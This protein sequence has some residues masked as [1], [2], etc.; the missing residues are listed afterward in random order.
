MSNLLTGLFGRRT[1]VV[2]KDVAPEDISEFYF[3]YDASTYPPEFQRYRLF[4]KDGTVFFYH[5]KREGDHWPL[6]EEDATVTGTTELS[7]EQWDEFF[8]LL[9][10]GIVR[11]REEHLEAG[12]SG[13]WLFLYWKNDRGKIQEYSFA[14]YENRCAFEKLCEELK[15]ADVSKNEGVPGAEELS[16]D[17][18]KSLL[19]GLAKYLSDRYVPEPQAFSAAAMAGT[20]ANNATPFMGKADAVMP[21]AAYMSVPAAEETSDSEEAAEPEPLEEEESFE[22]EYSTDAAAPE[23]LEE[24]AEPVDLDDQVA[25]APVFF[26]EKVKESFRPLRKAKKAGKY[27]A[28]QSVCA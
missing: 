1:A 27:R 21:M 14:S 18:R 13:P 2:G 8:N 7:E 5:E 20:A 22:Q 12:G 26:E 25:A 28:E 15:E 16:E 24:A 9:K 10:G 17:E 23:F 3:T 6:R 4:K 19:D 11:A